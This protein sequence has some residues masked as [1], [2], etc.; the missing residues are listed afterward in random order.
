MYEFLDR[1]Y[2][3]ALYKTCQEKGKVD[4][5][6]E[7]FEG[8]VNGMANNEGLIKII[9]HPQIS[10]SAKRRI[11]KEIFSGKIDEELLN[12]LILLIDRERILFLK[13]KYEQ[14]KLIHLEN[15]N[16]VIANVK[17]VISLS[18]EQR[19]RLK[20][21]LEY[22]YKKKV[23]L[24]EEI[25]PKLI[26]GLMIRVGSDVIDGSIKNKLTEFKDLSEGSGRS[27]Y[28]F[29]QMRKDLLA[30]VFTSWPLSY[31]QVEELKDILV[32]FY[33]KNI[34]VKQILDSNI[35]NDIKVVIGNDVMD[36]NRIMSMRDDGKNMKTKSYS[37]EEPYVN[38][39]D[40]NKI[41]NA[42]IKTVISL[43][44]NQKEKLIAALEKFY[45]RKIIITEEIDK[46]IVGGVL[47]RIGEDIT[48][49]TLKTKLRN[50]KRD[51]S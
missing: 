50:Y 17:T 46:T 12:F 7:E 20:D 44:I 9:K 48:D 5:I 32:K 47:V 23:I 33:N 42:H 34:I 25:D 30:E 38:S 36:R 35:V 22:M 14:F 1:R 21:K 39:Y 4:K 8:I 24:Q 26:G 18:S 49:G 2:A 28:N 13:E 27:R 6:M 31:E 11:F 10:K 40:K 29:V 3:L 41:L 16:T 43:N 19:E 51:L 37:Y 45:N 15:N